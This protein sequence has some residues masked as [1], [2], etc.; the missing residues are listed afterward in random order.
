MSQAGIAPGTKSR[1]RRSPT[2][3]FCA[4]AL[5]RGSNGA[6]GALMRKLRPLALSHPPLSWAP[7]PHPPPRALRNSA[8]Q[9]PSTQGP[10]EDPTVRFKI[11]E[12]NLSWKWPE[13]KRLGSAGGGPCRAR[14]CPAVRKGA[15]SPPADLAASGDRGQ[16]SVWSRV[17][18][19]FTVSEDGPYFSTAGG[20]FAAMG[21]PSTS[22]R[23]QLSVPV[24]VFFAPIT[25]AM[26]F[27]TTCKRNFDLRAPDPI[28]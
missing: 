14:L 6:P 25:C 5:A 20:A 15:P 4:D 13:S 19:S 2:G 21:I 27:S 12:Q 7:P 17:E 24:H 8:D 3:R 22:S 16:K 11:R 18:D 23:R 10:S 28:L 1:S 9:T 26:Y